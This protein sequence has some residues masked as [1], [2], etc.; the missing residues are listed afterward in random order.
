[1]M[2]AIVVAIVVIIGWL[3]WIDADEMFR[4]SYDEAWGTANDSWDST[5][6]PWE[7]GTNHDGGE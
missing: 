5:D 4:D 7:T 1:M 6:G 3:A 2:I